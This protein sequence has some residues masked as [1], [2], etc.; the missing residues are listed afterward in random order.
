M[1]AARGEVGRDVRPHA[2]VNLGEQAILGSI[3]DISKPSRFYG[4]ELNG[5]RIGV[6][7][8]NAA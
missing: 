6:T 1:Q 8:V 7:Y 4:C 3:T 5:M 2:R